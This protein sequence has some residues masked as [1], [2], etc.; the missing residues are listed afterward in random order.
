MWGKSDIGCSLNTEMYVFSG[1]FHYEIHLYFYHNCILKGNIS[2]GKLFQKTL[3]YN[4][5][6]DLISSDEKK[7]MIQIIKERP[8]YFNNYSI[9]HLYN[10]DAAI[11][12]D[13][14]VDNLFKDLGLDSEFGGSEQRIGSSL[15]KL[16]EASLKQWFEFSSGSEL[17][18]HV[19]KMSHNH[20]MKSKNDTTIYLA[21]QMVVDVTKAGHWNHLL[22]ECW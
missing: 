15:Y 1:G 22:K 14:I 16:V 4:K 19:K 12:N 3:L 11:A 18:N 5:S 9:G 10:Y 8:M 6:K 20:L 21:K 2:I 13:S 7:Y 17:Y